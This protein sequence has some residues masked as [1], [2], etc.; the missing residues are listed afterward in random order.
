MVTVA[1]CLAACHRTGIAT[2]AAVVPPQSSEGRAILAVAE[3]L[4]HA[5]RTKDSAEF[6]DVFEPGARLV[7]MRARQRGDTVLQVLTWE[8]FRDLALADTRGPWIE[9]AWSPEIRVRGSLATV[10]AQYDFHFGT[11]ASHCG[12]DALQLLKTSSGWKIVSIADTY[13]PS[14]CP[15]RAA[16]DTSAASK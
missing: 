4:F 12:V 8:R 13:E 10:W 2:D 11:R 7:G 6:R 3:R 14:G 15:E 1:M 9:R 16:P 5:M